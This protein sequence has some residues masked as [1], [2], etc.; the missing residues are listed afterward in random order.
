MDIITAACTDVGTSKSVNQDSYCIR[1]AET[2]VGSVAF[3]AVCDGMGGLD[4]GEYASASM[5]IAF[6]DWFDNEMPGFIDRVEADQFESIVARWDEIISNQNNALVVRGLQKRTTL[7]TTLTALLIVHKFGF[8]IAHIGDTRV[9]RIG[10]AAE[11]LTEDHTFVA[12]EI[13]YNRLTEQE[14]KNDPRRNILLQCIGVDYS[15]DISYIRDISSP[16][17]L[18]LIC[19]DGFR[20]V[21]SDEEIRAALTNEDMST[22]SSMRDILKNLT[23]ECIRRGETDNITSVLVNVR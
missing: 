5:T 3:A 22:E 1:I 21:L 4:F 6:A 20:H 9:Y 10:A 2:S 19:S 17:G 12:N 8:V 23:D 13:K 16:R 15:L 7:G 14:A 11:L 18:Y